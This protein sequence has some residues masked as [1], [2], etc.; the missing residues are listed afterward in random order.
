M[1]GTH[2]DIKDKKSDQD[3]FLAALAH[4]SGLLFG[5]FGP[6]II[7][8]LSNSEFVKENAL[9]SIS[10]QLFFTAYFLLSLI[11][12]FTGVGL[13]TLPLFI[14]FDLAFSVSAAIKA[15]D[16]EAWRYPLTTDIFVKTEEQDNTNSF[17]KSSQKTKENKISQLKQMYVNN[18]ISEKEFD[19]LIDE[20][21]ERN[22]NDENIERSVEKSY[23]K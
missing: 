6:M 16:G 2:M 4:I 21:L 1:D 18:E 23:Q 10:W 19:R 3:K 20:E 9:R 8:F 13:I 12:L 7:Y 15:K 5:V 11:L 14:V 22:E 17:S